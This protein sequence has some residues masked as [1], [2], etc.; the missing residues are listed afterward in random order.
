[1][2]LP[3]LSK[4]S[5]TY[6]NSTNALLNPFQIPFNMLCND[7]LEKILGYLDDEDAL[8]IALTCRRFRE[9]IY[10]QLQKT[11]NSRKILWLNWKKKLTPPN[12]I[13]TSEYLS[14]YLK[15]FTYEQA[16]DTQSGRIMNQSD[17]LFIT[18]ISSIVSNMNR[19][20]WV[21]NQ[22]DRRPR[23]LDPSQ[24]NSSDTCALL[25]KL[26]AIDALKFLQK[27]N[28]SWDH[29]ICSFAASGGHL[30]LLQWARTKGCPWNKNSSDEN[31]NSHR[32][33]LFSEYQ[34]KSD[35]L[36]SIFVSSLDLA[37]L[38][39]ACDYAAESGYID[40]LKYVL[41]HG[42]PFDELT[43]AMAARGGQLEVLK[44][45]RNELNCPWD[46]R[47]VFSA[48]AMGHLDV[49]KWTIANSCEST[50]I[51]HLGY[52]S[53]A[54][55]H[56]KV[57]KWLIEEKFYIDNYTCYYAASSGNLELF[58]LL[59]SIWLPR[60]ETN[61]ADPTNV[62]DYILFRSKCA[63]NIAKGGN[64]DMLKWWIKKKGSPYDYTSIMRL[65]AKFGHLKMM[66]WLF[67]EHDYRS[68]EL[69]LMAA[70]HGHL[71]LLKWLI[72]EGCPINEYK[73]T[74][75]A[76]QYGRLDVCQWLLEEKSLS[77]IMLQEIKYSAK[78]HEHN[79]LVILIEDKM[80]V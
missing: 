79:E 51:G 34:S 29:R 43:C 80:L 76:A 3:L 75:I 72:E 20:L 32:K 47:T 31:Y 48:A 13:K 50:S 17:K 39:N 2:V 6:N 4:C 40:I 9:H 57:V 61:F 45:L 74:K 18:S 44:F 52:V 58:K 25:A 33:L 27:K 11:K 67:V 30:E 22:K 59:V 14:T 62:A 71:E 49:L 66:Q 41:A 26:G 46:Y 54:G 78:M 63:N 69:T 5:A 24:K 65:T 19:F 53:A 8:W 28:Y 36:H 77:I 23:W 56:F 15:V 1:M 35:T 21:F 7:M 70:K 16:Y 60:Y 37:E 73:C 12:P 10:K 64:L 38:G 42:C 68:Y 55:G